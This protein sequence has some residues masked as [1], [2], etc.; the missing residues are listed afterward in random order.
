[1]IVSITREGT[2]KSSRLSVW[3]KAC[4]LGQESQLNSYSINQTLKVK[5][6]KPLPAGHSEKNPH[7]AV[8]Y[9]KVP[10]LFQRNA[11][12]ELFSDKTEKR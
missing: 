1:M 10:T 5:A 8:S 3:I 2:N 4:N 6:F 11:L 9:Y 7:C 12:F